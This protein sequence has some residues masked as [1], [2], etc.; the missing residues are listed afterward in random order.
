MGAQPPLPQQQQHEEEASA[1]HQ[2]PS[3]TS[4]LDSPAPGCSSQEAATALGCSCS[5]SSSSPPG[6]DSLAVEGSS[7][8]SGGPPLFELRIYSMDGPEF[9]SL[10]KAR[11]I[12]AA[13]CLTSIQFS[14]SG[15]FLLLAYGKRHISLCSLVV[16]SSRL[17]PVHSILE[18][19]RWAAGG[20]E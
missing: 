15:E 16:D 19:Y 9:G 12:H 8:S 2:P 18:I 13:H 7:G 6:G 20:G 5:S 3:V 4:L 14:P 11:P 1:R 17:L 10:L